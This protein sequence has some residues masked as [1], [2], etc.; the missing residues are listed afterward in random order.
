MKIAFFTDDYL[1]YIHGVTR[2]IQAYRT[3]LEAR[4]HEVWIVAPK[5]H[6]YVDND[7]HV[8]RTNSVNSYLFD[9]RP[10][11]IIYPGM[12]RIFDDYDF[13]VVHS[14]TQFWLGT[15]GY[16]TAKRQHIPHVS[17][18]HTIFPELLSAY[19]AAVIAGIIAVSIGYPI[20]YKTTPVLPFEGG[21]LENLRTTNR[22][23]FDNQAWKL[24][25][26]FMKHTSLCITPSQ[27]I[28]NTLIKHGLRTPHAVLANG[29]DVS[30]Y[31]QEHKATSVHKADG[32][33]WVVAVGRLSAEKRQQVMIEALQHTTVPGL[34]LVLVGEGPEHH[35]LERLANKLGVGDRIIFTG[36]QPRH[37]VAAI[38]QLAD[39]FAIASWRFDN[40]PMVILEAI[41]AGLPVIYCD[42]RLTEGL[43]ADNSLLT[44]SHEPDGFVKAFNELM[45][46]TARLAK[47]SQASLKLSKDFDIDA[48]ATKLEALYKKCQPV[49]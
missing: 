49:E 6:D 26:L 31:R 36:S 44:D 34:K 16:M 9:K 18:I 25:N 11:S 4:G 2:S 38:L 15:L 30:F 47:M 35:E 43:T 42:D 24:M 12:A 23:L 37:E 39:A 17:T 21:A 7:D 33:K 45:P 28:A 46:D 3:A 19:P 5:H 29:I 8:I 1:P 20:A 14:Q 10:M 48:Q 32:E 27:H 40:Q 41:A 22:K 13:D